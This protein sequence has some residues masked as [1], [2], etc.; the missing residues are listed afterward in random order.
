[1]G[2]L[3][4]GQ[5][6]P[7]PQSITLRF[8]RLHAIHQFFDLRLTLA[9]VVLQGANLLLGGVVGV[10]GNRH[11]SYRQHSQNPLSYIRL[12]FHVHLIAFIGHTL[13]LLRKFKNELQ[14]YF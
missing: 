2:Q 5:A 3:L 11:K 14:G 6:D 10:S 1:L 9:E 8:G 13:F 7:L 4:L 12:M